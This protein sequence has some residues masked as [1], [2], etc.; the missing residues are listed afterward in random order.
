MLHDLRVLELPSGI[1]GSYCAKL[2]ADAGAE[3]VKIE[4]P[5]GDPLRRWSASGADLGGDDGA[6]FRFLNTSKRSVVADLSSGE[7]EDL[8]AGA[9]VLVETGAVDPRR[10]AGRHPRLMIVSITR[11]GRTGPWAGR[12]ATE[13]TLQA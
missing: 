9:D 8:L 13:F 11:F 5:D 6:L 4:G 7:V 2:L 12:P 3:V 1:A 10:L